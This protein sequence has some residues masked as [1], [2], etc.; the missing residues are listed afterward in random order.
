MDVIHLRLFCAVVGSVPG[1]ARSWRLTSFG[2]W[3]KAASGDGRTW[4]CGS[5]G[6]NIPVSHTR[7][8]TQRSALWLQLHS[9]LP[10]RICEHF[11]TSESLLT[12]LLQQEDEHL[13]LQGHQ[14][15]LE[16]PGLQSHEAPW[17][18]ERAALQQEV[19]LFRRNTVIFYMKLRSMLMRRRLSCKEQEETAQPEVSP[20]SPGP[21]KTSV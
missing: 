20:W 14:G 21:E 5:T 3:T 1:N 13:H 17:T 7:T 10:V 12:T 6:T 15:G 8:H 19:R 16:L 11:K 4:G 9:P 18:Q 2:S